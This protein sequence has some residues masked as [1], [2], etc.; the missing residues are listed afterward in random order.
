MRKHKW[1]LVDLQK[2]EKWISN[3]ISKG[4]RMVDKGVG[5]YEFE[6]YEI[7]EI[8]P[9]IRI[10]Y[11]VFSN[12]NKLNDY[13]MLFEDSGWKHVAGGMN[14]EKHYFEKLTPDANEDIFSD[15][16]SKVERYKRVV[17]WNLFFF[18]L[19]MICL[20]ESFDTL[21]GIFHLNEYY[22]T[23]G[24]WEMKGTEFVS[25][26]L[27]ETPFAVGRGVLDSISI[28][29]PLVTILFILKAGY[30]YQREKRAGQMK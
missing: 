24:L 6:S 21:H 23:P 2:E 14:S 17:S 30:C 25:H 5:W 22:Y 9:I 10:D 13:I 15:H 18:F 28:I 3:T 29:M 16:R 11:R 7:G 20:V 1:F 26:F 4:Y 12:V 8:L 27:F 19:W